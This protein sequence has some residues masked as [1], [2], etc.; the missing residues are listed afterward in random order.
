MD[1]FIKCIS[2][3]LLFFIFIFFIFFIIKFTYIE[4]KP[5]DKIILK[6]N[7]KELPVYQV[8]N[9]LDSISIICIYKENGKL[10]YH[11]IDDLSLIKKII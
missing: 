2:F 1:I 7:N 4:I 10:F 6:N 5:G 11:R 3:F 8:F 9:Y